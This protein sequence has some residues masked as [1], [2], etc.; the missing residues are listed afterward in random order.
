ML[1]PS[2]LAPSI[3]LGNP[4]RLRNRF[5]DHVAKA[6][7]R[8]PRTN[9]KDVLRSDIAVTRRRLQLT[10]GSRRSCISGVEMTYQT[11]SG[12]AEMLLSWVTEIIDFTA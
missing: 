5:A 9:D 12:V 11:A 3:D 10:A 4:H 2:L 8:E 6:C 7:P 1:D